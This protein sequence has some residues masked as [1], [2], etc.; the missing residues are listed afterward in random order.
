VAKASGDLLSLRYDGLEMLSRTGGGRAGGYWSHNVALGGAVARVTIDPQTNGGERGEVSVK[1]MSKGQPL[2]SGPG[3]S[4]VADIEIRYCLERGVAGLYTYCIFEHQTNYPAF[5][6]GEARFCAKLNDEVFDWMTVDAQRNL[7]MLTA[8]DWNHG[9][10]M[11]MKEARFLNT[12]IHQGEVEHKYDY[13]ANQF[14]TRAWGWSSTAR[15]LGVW[16]INPSVEYLSGGPTKYELCAHRDA[17]FGTNLNAAAPPTLLNYW[18]SSHY[19]GSSCV[20]GEAEAWTK[21]IG[22]FLIYCNAGKAPDEVWQDALARAVC[23]ASKWPYQW[24]AG[25]DYPNRSQRGSVRGRLVLR[26]RLP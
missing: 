10:V 8:Y 19:G 17:T 13:S 21:V 22:P 4:A 7:K 15:G 24:V 9:T 23:E 25:V 11:N 18:R 20:I 16:F 3:G 14:E 5:S 26:D 1:A 6:L 12:G 2:G